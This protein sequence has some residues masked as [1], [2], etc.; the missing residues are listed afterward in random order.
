MFNSLR[1]R[2]LLWYTAIL[3][4]VI[5]VF[6]GAVSLLIWRARVADVDALLRER[7]MQLAATVQ[8][9]VGGTFDFGR[10]PTPAPPLEGE[11]PDSVGPY[12]ALWNPEGER[13]DSP[14]PDIDVPRPDE[15]G[16]WT[17]AGNREI[18]V[19]A[20]SDVMVLV[21]RSLDDVRAEILSLVATIAALGVVALALSLAGGWWLVG[22]ALEPV[23]RISRTARAMVGGDFGARISIDRVENELGLLA[24]ALNEAFDR[25]SASLERQR[26][27]TADASHELRTPLATLSTETQWALS[28]E[29]RAEE[30][31]HSLEVCSRAAGRMKSVV[32]RL[33]VLA[34]A[35]ASVTDRAFDVRLDEL[36]SDAVADLKPL[37]R[38]A[39][40]TIDVQTRYAVVRGD[41]ERLTEAVT[42]VLSNAIRYNVERG[43]IDVRLEVEGTE[44]TLRVADTGIG[45]GPVDLSRVFEPFFRADPARSRDV[46]GAGLGLAVARAIVERHGGRIRCGSELGQ[47]TEV[48]I[49]LPLAGSAAAREPEAPA[50]ASPGAPVTPP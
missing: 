15:P 16:T 44:A 19:R 4:L 5:L 29:R 22:R 24:R 36:V 42:N 47:G 45:I 49:T 43:R 32:E 8:P 25:L 17:R 37:A 1:A 3:A 50:A 14:N 41:V 9:T 10:L 26:R 2:L 23:D 12:Y 28:R 40:L 34:R 31:R 46:G 48:T 21:G 13:L 38:P 33:L 7:V 6:A 30:Y 35:E 11:A 39:G 20:A 27:F 18:A